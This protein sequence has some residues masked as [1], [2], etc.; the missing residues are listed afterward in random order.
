M[1]EREYWGGLILVLVVVVVA[2]VW[3]LSRVI[4]A[5]FKVT[6]E[7]LF[8]SV[9]AIAAAGGVWYFIKP[10]WHVL[11]AGS[12]LIL[13]PLWWPVLGSI[14]TNG[15]GA[16]D[17]WGYQPQVMPWWNT[18]WFKYGIEVGLFGALL[19]LATRPRW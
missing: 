1:N 14:A 6:G 19:Y 16:P 7:A 8:R 3:Y 11:L 5:D 10:R 4:G 15:A 13:W 2:G 18:N 17:I 9:G 12:L